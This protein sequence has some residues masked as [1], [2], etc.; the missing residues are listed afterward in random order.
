MKEQ[1]L[2]IDFGTS[3]TSASTL[4]ENG[5][6][7][8][9]PLQ[10][11]LNTQ[12]SGVF[13]RQDGYNSVGYK[14]ISD[15]MNADPRK[16]PFHYIPSIK[17]ALPITNYEGIGLKALKMDNGRY[18]VK[19]FETEEITSYIIKDVLIHASKY[20]NVN[21]RVVLGRPVKFSDNLSEDNLAQNRLEAAVRLAGFNEIHFVFEPVAAAINYERFQMKDKK[22]MVFV[23]DFGGGTLDTCVLKLGNKEKMSDK[24]ISSYG[25]SLGGTDL[26]KDVFRRQLL[27]Y[28]GS[29]ATFGPNRS[30]MPYH[31]FNDLTE[32]HLYSRLNNSNVL[33]D[34]RQIRADKNCSDKDAVERLLNLIQYQQVPL[35]LQS[36]ETAKI[37]LSNKENTNINFNSE[38]LRV[39]IP[40]NRVLF[41]EAIRSRTEEIQSCISEC[42]LLAGVKEEKIDIALKVGGSSKNQFVDNILKTRFSKVENTTEL[43]SVAAGLGLIA[44]EL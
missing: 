36:V 14:A 35:V 23:F 19:F 10:R 43:T 16:E 38:T 8:L 1:K 3:N 17:Q 41:N 4:G 7:F 42:L 9:F 31:I 18:P 33:N 28:F 29:Q 26:D 37:A 12:P 5:R 44:A 39:N 11:D 27:Q 21:K 40:L 20:G 22:S 6:I 15:Y 25:V 24:I 13:L 30:N 34:L 32:W 2:G